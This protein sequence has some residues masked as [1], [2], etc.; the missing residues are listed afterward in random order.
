MAKSRST[1]PWVCEA[2]GEPHEGNV[3]PCEGCGHERFVQ[4]RAEVVPDERAARTRFEWRCEECDR[5]HDRKRA[6]CAECEHAGLA[7]AYGETADEEGVDARRL[8]TVAGGTARWLVALVAAT[9]ALVVGVLFLLGGSPRFGGP[10][11]LAGLLTLP[12]VERRIESVA[13][14][15]VPRWLSALVYAL[16]WVGG[17]ALYNA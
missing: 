4:L 11:A 9:V 1:V 10:V 7:P 14:R 15:R 6:R 2:C 3:P 13:G 5:A 8:L 17:L 16:G 12:S